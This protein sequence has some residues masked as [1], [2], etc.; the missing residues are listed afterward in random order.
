MEDRIIKGTKIMKGCQIL[1][2][3]VLR[4]IELKLGDKTLQKM[5]MEEHLFCTYYVVVN[6]L[7][8]I[9]YS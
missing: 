5:K 9:M 6:S 3:S 4:R 7:G 1:E 8:V 2:Y